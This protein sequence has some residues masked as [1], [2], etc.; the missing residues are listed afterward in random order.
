ML[1]KIKIYRYLNSS[2]TLI[3]KAL[4]LLIKNAKVIIAFSILMR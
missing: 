2:L 4:K 3:V 1:I